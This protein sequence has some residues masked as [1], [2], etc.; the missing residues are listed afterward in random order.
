MEQF[1]WTNKQK[2]PNKHSMFGHKTYFEL[3]DNLTTLYQCCKTCKMGIEVKD[4]TPV[5][6]IEKLICASQRE[7]RIECCHC[8]SVVECRAK[9][10]CCCGIVLDDE[11]EKDRLEKKERE[12]QAMIKRDPELADMI[13]KTK[14]GEFPIFKDI[15]F[16]EKNPAS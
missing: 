8:T 3:S 5:E 11:I 14:N 9:H 4:F 16:M 1:S 6:N 15:S 13:C 10:N 2:F 12:A 7:Y